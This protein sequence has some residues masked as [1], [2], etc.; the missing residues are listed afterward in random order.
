MSEN[1]HIDI[2]IT[3]ELR[4]WLLERARAKGMTLTGYIRLILLTF[5]AIGRAPIKE[6][7]NGKSADE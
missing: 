1:V 6:V 3:P 7:V 2:A 4:Q 5:Q